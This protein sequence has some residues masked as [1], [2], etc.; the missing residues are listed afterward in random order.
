MLALTLGAAPALAQEVYR[1][2]DENGVVHYSDR[3]IEGAEQVDMAPLQTYT[4]RTPR[5]PSSFYPDQPATAPLFEYSALN[6]VTPEPGGAVWAT[7]GILTVVV[8]L[9]PAL[10]A[11]DR[12]QLEVDGMLVNSAPAGSNEIEVTG[13]NRGPHT[14]RAIV[15]DPQGRQLV[16]SEPIEFNVLQS[17]IN[18]PQRRRP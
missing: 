4:D 15:V 3:P 5:G 12:V 6:F 16:V 11:V 8:E 2:V 10:R 9:R 17:S 13:L 18:N 7:G 14:L 1:W